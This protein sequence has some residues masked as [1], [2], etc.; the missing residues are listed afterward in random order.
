MTE[1]IVIR[2]AT[3]ADARVIAHHRVAMFQDM[4]TLPEDL[5]PPLREA[6]QRAIAQ[7]IPSGEYVGWLATPV[8]RP[9][10]VIA[11]AGVHVRSR[12]PR[13]DRA[14]T[15]V[16]PGPQALIVNVYT[17]RPWRRRGVAERLMRAVL[18]WTRE[19]GIDDVVLHASAEGRRLY[20]KLGFTA[21]NE[22]RYQG[23]AAIR[24]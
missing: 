5:A 2:P 19:R 16:D 13:A 4:G 8:G 1:A 10:E 6:S 15:R 22:M 18:D 9:V 14:R 11:G 21:T 20:E 24:K 12:L 3:A 23:E 17:E 7:M